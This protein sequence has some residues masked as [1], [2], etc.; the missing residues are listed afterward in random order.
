MFIPKRFSKPKLNQRGT[1]F[2]LFRLLL[3]PVAGPAFSHR[4]ACC[5]DSPLHCSLSQ[6]LSKQDYVLLLAIFRLWSLSALE[7]FRIYRTSNS[8]GTQLLRV[9]THS[10]TTKDRLQPDSR[11]ISFGIKVLSIQ[12]RD[13]GALRTSCRYTDEARHIIVVSCS[14]CCARFCGILSWWRI[15]YLIHLAPRFISAPPQVRLLSFQQM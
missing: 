6:T 4:S 7:K 15:E 8:P 11:P 14:N 12:N 2:P 5:I 10:T 3:P 1:A 9:R 13:R